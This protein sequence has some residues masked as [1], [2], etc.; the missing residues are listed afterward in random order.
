MRERLEEPFFLAIAAFVLVWAVARASLQSITFDEAFSYLY[1][2]KTLSATQDFSANNHVLNSLLMLVTTHL[3]G[4]S[5]LS[6]RMPAL[7]GA[8]LYVSVCYLLCRRIAPGFALRLGLFVCLTFNPFI[9]DFMAAARGY[10]LANALLMSAIAIQILC[11]PTPLWCALASLSLGLSFC[12]NF[13]FAF[14]DF[15]AFL[16]LLVWAFRGREAQSALGLLANC[17]LPGALVTFVICGYP[18]THRGDAKWEDHLYWGAHS[19]REMRKSLVEA[20]LYELDPALPF[21]NFAGWFGPKLMPGLVFLCLART[22]VAKPRVWNLAAITVSAF[23]ASWLAFHF[24]G[25]PLPLGRTGIYFVTL[26]TLGMGVIASSPAR[27][28]LSRWLQLGLVVSLL[29]L[30][31]YFVL[32]LRLS[33]FKAYRW[34]ADVKDAYAVLA[35]LNQTRGLTDV[36][37]SGVFVPGLNFYRE[38]SGQETFSEFEAETPEVVAGRAAYVL[39]EGY[40]ADFI[41]REKLVVI[42][43]G[44]LS[45]TVVALSP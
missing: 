34:N 36:Q 18:L 13:S 38:V 25:L 24:F 1:F 16:A 20:S 39:N 5:N 15:S 44:K 43:R 14:A 40:W 6:V 32:C 45:G 35:R 27:G 22:I 8:L 41:R 9:L 7:L 33:Y 10:S 31:S 21:S 42:Y 23:A 2:G 11:R 19:V 12:A 17:T 28:L 37:T 3:F 26:C 4:P 30:G 29:G